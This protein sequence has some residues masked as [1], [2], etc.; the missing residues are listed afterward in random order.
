MGEL[1]WTNLPF[2]ESKL[3]VTSTG[4]A[5][6]RLILIVRNSIE[7]NVDVQLQVGTVGTGVM[8]PLYP[9]D[10]LVASPDSPAEVANPPRPKRRWWQ[11]F[12]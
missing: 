11:I 9:S 6:R 4:F 1:V 7:L 12:R 8:M 3:S 5:T 10:P 2:G